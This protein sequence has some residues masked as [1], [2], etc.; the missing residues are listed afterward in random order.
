MR[1]PGPMTQGSGVL[2]LIMAH[3]LWFYLDDEFFCP[4]TGAS[5]HMW[6]ADR[7]MHW[8]E[9]GQTNQSSQVPVAK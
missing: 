9:G 2:V 1:V 7:K 3:F 8:Q 4:F 5:T 6:E